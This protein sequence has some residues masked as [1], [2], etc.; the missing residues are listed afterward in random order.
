T[1]AVFVAETKN[2]G[3]ETRQSGA[4]LRRRSFLADRTATRQGH[5][6]RAQFDGRYEP[7]H[8]AGFLMDRGND[9][10]GSVAARVAGTCMDDP[11]GK[12]QRERK[13]DE[14]RDVMHERVRP[15]IRSLQG[16][17]KDASAQAYA[18]TRGRT[19]QRPL[20]RADQERGVFGVP[21]ALVGES[22]RL[23]ARDP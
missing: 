21:A 23:V 12:R 16:P 6:R 18:Y 5:D 14:W 11:G 19:K 3:E 4:D 10:L 15:R 9:R 17:E 13:Q 20:E 1:P 7:I 22:R 2:V 8:A